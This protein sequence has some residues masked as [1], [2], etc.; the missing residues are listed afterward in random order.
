MKTESFACWPPRRGYLG[1][2]YVTL[3][4]LSVSCDRG[5]LWP[6]PL[7]GHVFHVFSL[8]GLMTLTCI[9]RDAK[10]AVLWPHIVPHTSTTLP[11]IKQMLISFS[12]YLHCF[13][14]SIFF[15][16][17]RHFSF[18]QILYSSSYIRKDELSEEWHRA[19]RP[20][21][22]KIPP[23]T[24]YH[25]NWVKQIVELSVDILLL[26]LHYLLSRVFRARIVQ[27]VR[28]LYNGLDGRSSVSSNKIRKVSL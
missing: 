28:W 6:L 23:Q 17:P 9:S 14:S 11:H 26:L 15:F 2:N 3:P 8:V 10:S 1:T 13:Y 25:K 5:C 20:Q 16:L 21:H 24:R 18:S 12:V 27:S 22:C 4:I 19:T 7:P